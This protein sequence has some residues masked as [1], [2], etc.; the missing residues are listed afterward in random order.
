MPI[1]DR[2]ESQLGSW[3]GAVGRLVPGAFVIV[4]T[5]LSLDAHQDLA[6][7]FGRRRRFGT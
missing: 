2:R 4:I 3:A 1:E 7:R 6:A 5:A